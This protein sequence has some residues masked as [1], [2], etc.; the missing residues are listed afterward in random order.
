M[1]QDYRK[2]NANQFNTLISDFTKN[3]LGRTHRN[4]AKAVTTSHMLGKSV[5]VTDEIIINFILSISHNC[6][7]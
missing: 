2:S 1:Y 5:P 3:K 6:Y 7:L 4:Y